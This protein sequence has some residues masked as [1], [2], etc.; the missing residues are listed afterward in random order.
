MLFEKIFQRNDKS[1][2]LF[3]H[4]SLSVALYF[5]STLAYYFRN[6]TW[7]LSGSYFEASLI[8]ALTFLILTIF[9]FTY[10]SFKKISASLI[11]IFH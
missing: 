11:F 1:F 6:K 5:T 10:Y 3:Y 4:L 2:L 8:I 9:L 7:E